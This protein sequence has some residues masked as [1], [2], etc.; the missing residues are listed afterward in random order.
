M[1]STLTVSPVS[2]ETLA[3][4]KAMVLEI[5]Q[6]K[7]TPDQVSDSANL[8]NDCGL[9]STSVVELVVALEQ[10]FDITIDEDELD[11]RLFQDIG[12]LGSFVEAK[13]AENA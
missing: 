9:D 11:V 7:I 12:E 10:E 4:L 13:R 8:F 6:M 1:E 3:K 5:T 2:P